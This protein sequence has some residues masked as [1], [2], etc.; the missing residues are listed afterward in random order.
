M[1]RFVYWIAGLGLLAVGVALVL[2]WSP[3]QP[4]RPDQAEALKGDPVNGEY[5]AWVAGCVAC[6]TAKSQNAPFLAGDRELKTPFGAFVSPNIT[7]DPETGIGSWSTADFVR[8]MTQG[9]SPE[10]KHYYPAFPYTSYAKMSDQD[11]ADLKSF[12]DR[13][14]AVK[15]MPRDHD[16]PLPFRA[17]AAL[18]FW[19]TLYFD[20]APFK[21]HLGKSKAWNRGYYYVTGP[22]HCTECHTPRG[23]L[24][25]LDAS[26]HLEGNP[27]GGRN[28]KVPGL[29]AG[30]GGNLE[31]WS[32]SDLALALGNGLTPDGDSMGGSMGD[33]VT[34]ATRFLRPDDRKSVIDYL[35][36][37]GSDKP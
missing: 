15:A 9:V 34:F 20:D 17:R 18:T 5:L 31:K 37:A 14:P 12:L 7:P 21:A 1:P 6:H 11:L 4:T 22:G 33:V 23:L 26:R 36:D 30:K 25:G 16:L 28:E 29:T 32:R 8:A 19:K 24:G 13:I 27:K 35:L 10:G 3:S 2:S